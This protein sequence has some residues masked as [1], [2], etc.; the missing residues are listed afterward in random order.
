MSPLQK[1]VIDKD[2]R[3]FGTPVQRAGCG[4]LRRASS[5][6]DPAL[7]CATPARRL[8]TASEL[9]GWRP[10]C[11]V[12]QVRGAATV[13]G[14]EA[15]AWNAGCGHCPRRCGPPVFAA[16]TLDEPDLARFG[17]PPQVVDVPVWRP[18]PAQ[19]VCEACREPAGPK[20]AANIG[21]E[22]GH[23]PECSERAQPDAPG[24]REL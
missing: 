19:V 20:G 23:E 18:R 17:V 24:L 21:V 13:A 9:P 14:A 12:K 8:E 5:A 3:Q 16:R 1:C 2:F 15:G 22:P 4:T 6:H 11:K 7:H 10:I